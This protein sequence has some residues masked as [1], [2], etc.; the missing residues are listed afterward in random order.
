MIS[1]S[2]S[3]NVFEGCLGIVLLPFLPPRAYMDRHHFHLSLSF[4]EGDGVT[5]L[6]N[7]LTARLGIDRAE[8]LDDRYLFI[9]ACAVVVKLESSG[10]VIETPARGYLLCPVIDGAGGIGPDVIVSQDALEDRRVAAQLRVDDLTYQREHGLGACL[11][12]SWLRFR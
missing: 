10:G 5:I 6:V 2:L 7:R 11:I 12:G 1:S 9:N 8:D 4:A 3:V